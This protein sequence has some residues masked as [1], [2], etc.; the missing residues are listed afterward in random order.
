[1][2]AQDHL[3]HLLSTYHDL[4]HL[5]LQYLSYQDL[6][7][8]DLYLQ[9][10]A[11]FGDNNNTNLISLYSV[12]SNGLP[13][14]DLF[15]TILQPSQM[16][17]LSLRNLSLQKIQIA[18]LQYGGI[19]YLSRYRNNFTSLKFHNSI[20]LKS[21]HFS[22]CYFP[23]L[24]SLSLSNCLF[25]V[26]V[27]SVFLQLH[28]Q[29]L[30][31]LELHSIHHIP[32]ILSIFQRNSGISRIQT[33]SVTSCPWFGDQAILRVIQTVASLKSIN[34]KGSPVRQHQSIVNLTEA[35]PNL[36]SI[37]F[38]PTDFETNVS[39]LLARDIAYRSLLLTHD[40]ESQL[41]GLQYFHDLFN[42][43]SLS[44]L[45]PQEKLLLQS[46]LSLDRFIPRLFETFSQ[47]KIGTEIIQ[48][49]LKTNDLFSI[50]MLVE[51]GLIPQLL[52]LI[53]SQTHFELVC[54]A[55][56][57]LMLFASLDQRHLDLLLKNGFINSLLGISYQFT[58][59]IFQRYPLL[60]LL[61][62]T[63]TTIPPSDLLQLVV[64]L[65]QLNS[66][67]QA[68]SRGT[69]ARASTRGTKTRGE[70][71]PPS[72]LKD[73]FQLLFVF[74]ENQSE[75]S[76]LQTL[77]DANVLPFLEST[78]ICYSSDREC[79][80]YCCQFLQILDLSPCIPFPMKTMGLLY[81]L[82]SKDLDL[83]SLSLI[84]GCLQHV[85]LRDCLTLKKK[86]KFC[87]V[88]HAHESEREKEE[89]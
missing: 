5:I 47:G 84:C 35:Y 77:V 64:H 82:L 66:T 41:S 21:C 36:Q 43:K 87:C 49:I 15:E 81:S 79:L 27:L 33:L 48:Q 51:A 8:F 54:S 31:T 61:K 9:N 75:S 11:H 30:Q 60:Q 71:E 70:Q 17:W 52:Q 74:L 42:Y 23:K 56:D 24:T 65:F 63:V 38:N 16:Q 18:D 59:L 7:L 14:F 34:F 89:T 68:T 44:T 22:T 58:S 39:A 73:T 67:S 1:M 72:L 76:F 80:W 50:Q 3:T 83:E 53:P 12:S 86:R 2:P 69:G 19:E 29:I 85:F 46:T 26:E 13:F 45:S 88:T 57:V 40:P 62:S 37:Y 28:S 32:S 20:N 6:L 78:L 4:F 25:D 55:M 10:T